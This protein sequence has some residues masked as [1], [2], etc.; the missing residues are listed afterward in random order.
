MLVKSRVLASSPTNFILA[1]KVATL[2]ALITA[3]Y[4]NLTLFTSFFFSIVLLSLY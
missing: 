2:L 4:S 1:G 3:K